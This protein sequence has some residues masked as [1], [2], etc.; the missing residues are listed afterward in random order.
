MVVTTIVDSKV[1]I[2]AGVNTAFHICSNKCL[3]DLGQARWRAEREGGE[4]FEPPPSDPPEPVDNGRAPV[5]SSGKKEREY[6]PESREKMRLN[7]IRLQHVRGNHAAEPNIDCELC[8]AET[9][10]HEG[11]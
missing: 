5:V 10:P 8:A 4:A 3:R 1:T 2:N 9:A 6:T 7:G 11:R